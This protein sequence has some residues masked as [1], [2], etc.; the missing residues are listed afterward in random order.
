MSALAIRTKTSFNAT[1]NTWRKTWWE[2]HNA[3][4]KTT[5]GDD[6]RTP[7]DTRT[8]NFKRRSKRNA[9]ANPVKVYAQ[10]ARGRIRLHNGCCEGVARKE[11]PSQ[12]RVLDKSRA[13]ISGRRRLAQRS[14]T[15]DVRAGYAGNLQHHAARR[16]N[17]GRARGCRTRM[18]AS[19][20]SEMKAMLRGRG[21]E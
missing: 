7:D 21:G 12:Q 14:E 2:N 18:D 16:G 1:A 8:Q 4:C 9:C 17:A 3:N 15:A 5:E 6:F 11:A 20:A 10:A 13:L 19:V